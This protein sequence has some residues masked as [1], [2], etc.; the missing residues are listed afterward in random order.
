MAV[1]VRV[2]GVGLA[3]EPVPLGA[4]IIGLVLDRDVVVERP[5][6]AAAQPEFMRADGIVGDVV[7]G[8]Q[9]ARVHRHGGKDARRR[10]C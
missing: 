10:R 3:V 8:G 1:E 4:V 9:C 6:E 2:E 7:I 5:L